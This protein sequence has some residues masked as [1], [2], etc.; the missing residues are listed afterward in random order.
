MVTY[1]IPCA[2]FLGDYSDGTQRFLLFWVDGTGV[3]TGGPE[4]LLS[5]WTGD[6]GSTEPILSAKNIILGTPLQS[7]AS[8]EKHLTVPF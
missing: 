6:T 2:V 8:Q 3:L 1:S 5:V 7:S 4:E